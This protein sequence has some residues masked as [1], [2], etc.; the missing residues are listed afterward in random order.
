ML[1]TVSIGSCTKHCRTQKNMYHLLKLAS[2]SPAKKNVSQSFDKL[3][4]LFRGISGAEPRLFQT[5]CCG[6]TTQSQLQQEIQQQQNTGQGTRSLGSIYSLN[7][8]AKRDELDGRNERDQ[9][10]YDVVGIGEAIIDFSAKVEDKV[11]EQFKVAK[12]GRRVITAEER[13]EVLDILNKSKADIEVN[14]GGSLANTLVG[15]SQLSRAQA[16]RNP[17]APFVSPLNI[18]FTCRIGD[19]PHGMFFERSLSQHGVHNLSTPVDNTGTGMVIVLTS[20][21]A[22]RTF[23]AHPGNSQF[24][25]N[26]AIKNKVANS[27]MIVIE[28]YLLEQEQAF[29]DVVKLVEFANQQGVRVVLAAGDAGLVARSRNKFQRLIEIGVD[30]FLGNVNEGNAYF[31]DTNLQGEELSLRLASCCSISVITDGAKGS[32]IGAMG[33]VYKI[34]PYW[35]RSAPV[36]TTGAGDAYAAGVLFGLLQNFTLEEIG[37]LGARL[38]S[39]VIMDTKCRT[40]QQQVDKIIQ[41]IQITQE[42]QTTEQRAYI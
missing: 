34:D 10:Q 37:M 40:E 8:E 4:S 29:Q 7:G 20:P 35:L 25:I 31:N 39:E 15:I 14:A 42:S 26:D 19:D 11:L 9:I 12:G 33:Q 6:V 23:L 41:E 21:D 32:Y 30:A 5:Y 36:D 24:R 17:G 16:R 13:L 22:Q 28:G 2:F 18:A 1:N 3:G 38:A 27:Q